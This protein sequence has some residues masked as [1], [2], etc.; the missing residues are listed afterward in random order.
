MVVERAGERLALA[1]LGPGHGGAR[2]HHL[3]LAERAAD[4]EAARVHLDQR[5]A[6]SQIEGRKARVDLLRDAATELDLRD[7]RRA[8]GAAAHPPIYGGVWGAFRRR[9]APRGGDKF[10]PTRGFG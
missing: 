10:P 3:D 7:L 1:P 5:L 6:E 8:L 9:K 2:G 4:P